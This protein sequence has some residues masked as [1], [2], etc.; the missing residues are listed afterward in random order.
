[1]AEQTNIINTI[2][3]PNSSLFYSKEFNENWVND[4]TYVYALDI[5]FENYI[6]D[7]LNFPLTRIIYAQ[8]AYTFYERERKNDGLLNLP[9][10]NYYRTGYSE[11]DRP[12]FN[13]W[14]NRLYPLSNDE[15]IHALG[16]KIKIFPIKVEYEATCFFSQQ[17]DMEYAYTQLMFEA[18]N[19]TIIY[20]IVETTNGD[21]VKNIGIVSFDLEYNPNFEEFD[22][23]E[24]NKIFSIG[25]DFNIDTFMYVGDTSNIT[26]AKEIVEEFVSAKE[27]NKDDIDKSKGKDYIYSYFEKGV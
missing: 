12:W 26:L 10:L 21:T 16:Q 8:N 2:K 25:M 5:E 20:P 7:V 19:E 23:L 15:Q 22:Y 11:A 17:K 6:K 3:I 18:S 14:A 1:M 9:Y 4:K 13:N 27:L 24:K